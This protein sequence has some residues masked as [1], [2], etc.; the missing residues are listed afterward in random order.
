M[1]MIAKMIFLEKKKTSEVSTYGADV[2]II[3]KPELS[4]LLSER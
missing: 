2:V 4:V 1:L 3:V